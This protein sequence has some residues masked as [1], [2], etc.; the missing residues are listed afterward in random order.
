MTK[1]KKITIVVILVVLILLTIIGTCIA[2]YI[3]TDMFKTSK[4]LFAKYLGQNSDN[5]MSLE[6]IIQKTQ[7]DSMQDKSPYN[8]NI[9]A[10]I[11]YTE[12]IGT[13]EEN[14]KNSVNDLKV[15]ISQENDNNGYDYRNVKLLKSGEQ[16]AQIEYM[17]SEGECGIK[18]SDLF[19]QYI[20]TENDDLKEIFIKMGYT[21]DEIKNIPK[22]LNFEQD[23]LDEIKLS[24]GEL[25]NLQEKYVKIVEGNIIEENFSRQKNQIVTINNQNYNANAYILTLT[26]EQLNSIYVELLETIKQDEIIVNK[27]NV[28][29]NKIDEME[30]TTNL[31]EE[32][33]KNIDLT[34]QKIK[35]NNIGVDET[36]I[37]VYESNGI[38]LRTRV[39]TKDYQTNI[40]Y[41]GLNGTYFAE[42]LVSNE[43]VEKYKVTLNYSSDNLSFT[44]QDNSKT[45]SLEF[46]RID[47]VKE[48][49]ANRQY[50][51][52]YSID[53]KKIVA[54]IKEEI[55]L[56]ENIENIQKFT[57]EN[58][59][60]ANSLDD[61]T[62]AKIKESID[63]KIEETKEKIVY[64]DIEKMLKDTKIVQDFTILDSNGITD[65]ER[66]RF[67]SNFELLKGENLSGENILQTINII[68]NNIE[69]ME[70]VSGTE[71]KIGIVRDGGNDEVITTLTNFFEENTRKSYNVSLEYDENGL[72]NELVLTIVEDE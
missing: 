72:V 58:S 41:L 60:N 4:V 49:S 32:L 66:N 3:N 65:T 68:K 14:N 30:I 57:E 12:D 71:L 29:Q 16:V 20:I 5:L 18:F 10:D 26:K 63:G 50:N 37:I 27:I 11:K 38:T 23:F 21:E 48:N 19:N 8:K 35:Q 7:Y 64:Q 9:E 55:E 44:I 17:K 39:E 2:L 53:D 22:N 24:E 28:Q 36:K 51:L 6:N 25:L 54:N 1:K 52:S 70:I 46:T 13:S 62:K 43:K 34:I 56:S 67:N 15:F 47:E 33:I 59:V 45:A 61:E 31:K 42:I 69:D 40:D